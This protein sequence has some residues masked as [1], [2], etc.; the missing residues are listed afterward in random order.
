LPSVDRRLGIGYIDLILMT[1]TSV[2][3]Q[4]FAYKSG[5]FS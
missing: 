1:Y 5:R 4:K 2:P 3:S